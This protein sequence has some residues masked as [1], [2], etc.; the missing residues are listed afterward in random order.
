VSFAD[1]PAESIA[2]RRIGTPEDI[3]GGVEFFVAPDAGW[4]S[5]QTISI[6]GGHSLFRWPARR[7]AHHDGQNGKT[8]DITESWNPTHD[9]SGH[10][11]GAA[12]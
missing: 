5:G 11:R 1:P 9:E 8:N 3:A 12:A 7:V 2:M 6:D 4:V 10:H